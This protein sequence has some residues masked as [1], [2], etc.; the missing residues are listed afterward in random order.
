MVNGNKLFFNNFKLTQRRNHSVPANS[1]RTPLKKHL[2]RA[3]FCV[4][5]IALVAAVPVIAQK[6]LERKAATQTDESYLIRSGDKLS[7]KFPYHTELDE[8]SLVVRPDGYITLATIGEVRVGG[9]TVPQVKQRLEKAY[10]EV[11]VNPLIS[12]NLIEFQ[13]AHVFVGGQ[14]QKAGSFELRSGQ[15]LLQAVMLA[16]GFTNDANRRLV[17]HARPTGDGKLRVT[18]HDALTMISDTKKAYDLQ[19]QD[20]DY[21]FV[22]DSKLTKIARVMDAFRSVLPAANLLY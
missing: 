16:G 14:V 17:L 10:S 22:P 3:W 11:L 2:V 20:G 4:E 21:I 7:I 18:Q 19:L 1:H 12:V 8:P 15:T 6:M 13:M 9:Q 5:L